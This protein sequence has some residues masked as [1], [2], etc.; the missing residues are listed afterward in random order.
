MTNSLQFGASRPFSYPKD[1]FASRPIDRAPVASTAA[2]WAV[3]KELS[4]QGNT[5]AQAIVRIGTALN[6]KR[7]AEAEGVEVPLW[8]QDILAPIEADGTENLDDALAALKAAL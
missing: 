2:A 4:T 8:A 1:N 6:A 3:I 7:Q 5:M